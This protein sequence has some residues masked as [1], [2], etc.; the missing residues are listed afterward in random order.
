[1]IAL[2]IAGFFCMFIAFTTGVV[3]CW[4]T[5]PGHIV[6]SA[7]MMLLACKYTFFRFCCLDTFLSPEGT[8]ST[9]SD[10]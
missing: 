10:A 8:V 2:F 9:E 5:A 3:G 7:I 1:M 4:K 6:S